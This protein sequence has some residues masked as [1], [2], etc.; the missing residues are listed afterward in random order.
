MKSCIVVFDTGR[1]YLGET[2][3]DLGENIYKSGSGGKGGAGIALFNGFLK[4]QDEGID[5]LVQGTD[6][7]VGGKAVSGDLLL[8]PTYAIFQIAVALFRVSAV[9]QSFLREF[10]FVESDLLEF[11]KECTFVLNCIVGDDYR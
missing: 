6:S 7:Q 1:Q 4:I 9:F 8:K 2:E 11:R 3:T 10:T 5:I